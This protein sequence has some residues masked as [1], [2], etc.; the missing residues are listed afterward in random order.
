M[1]IICLGDSHTYGLGISRSDIWTKVSGGMLGAEI[2]N[3]GISGDTT[4]GM[5]SRL[6]KD[7]FSLKPDAVFL[8]GG[9][10]DLIAGA[11]LGVVQ[12]N[13]MS[14][15][16]IIYYNNILPIVGIPVKPDIKNMRYDWREFCDFQK[17]I[18]DLGN[19]RE[20]LKK[21]C[22]LFNTRYIDFWWEYDNRMNEMGYNL[23]FSDGVHP[24]KEGHAVIAE[25]FSSSMDFLI[26]KQ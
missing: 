24:T 6:D 15:V 26:K 11:D 16:H 5:L 20:W 1:K 25:I 12:A 17:V 9:T 7:V 2:I 18:E 14:I 4:G 8:M 19:Y 22:R 10:N 3:K 13:I 21:F 23:H